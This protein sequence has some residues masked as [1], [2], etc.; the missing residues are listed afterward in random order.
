MSFCGFAL[1]RTGFSQSSVACAHF[2]DIVDPYGADKA[3]FSTSED[4]YV[5]G[6]GYLPFT[7]YGIYVVNHKAAWSDGDLLTRV[8]GTES[9][10][11]SDGAGNILPTIVWHAPLTPGKYD[12]V[13]D[14]DGNGKYDAG[15]DALDANDVQVAAGFFAVP[16][17]LLGAIMGLAGLFAA[18]GVYRF[19]KRRS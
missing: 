7:T 5:N 12:I 13:I 10:A 16:E 18:L 15:T 14:V 19:S 11:S 8:A 3:V 6:S 1:I 9:T 2:V 17:F 4:V